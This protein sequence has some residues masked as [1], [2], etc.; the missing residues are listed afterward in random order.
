MMKTHAKLLFILL[1][2]QVCVC[3]AV[4]V[5][6]QGPAYRQYSDTGSLLVSKI[7]GTANGDV[8]TVFRTTTADSCA[9]IVQRSDSNG[10][11]RWTTRWP[12]LSVAEAAEAKNGDLLFSGSEWTATR[13]GGEARP[14]LLRTENDGSLLWRLDA[15]T[16]YP[17]PA[18][19]INRDQR[20]AETSTG[21][22]Y[23]HF[24]ESPGNTNDYFIYYV[25]AN[26]NTLWTRRLRYPSGFVFTDFISTFENN[27]LS[28]GT[29]PNGLAKGSFLIGIDSATN[30][31]FIRTITLPSSITIN[32]I[33]KDAVRR[34]YY[35]C[36]DY[37]DLATGVQAIVAKSGA[38]VASAISLQAVVAYP[39]LFKC[40]PAKRIYGLD[41]G[42]GVHCL[43]VSL[44]P[45]PLR[46]VTDGASLNAQ[47]PAWKF[48]ASL[49]VVW[50]KRYVMPL[51]AG[52]S[53]AFTSSPQLIFSHNRMMAAL[54]MDKPSASSVW[55][56][57]TDTAGV[58]A[59]NCVSTPEPFTSRNTSL[60]LNAVRANVVVPGV[61][62]NPSQTLV[63]QGYNVMARD[64]CIAPRK[65]KS[66]FR[67]AG[68]G[69]AICTGTAVSFLKHRLA[70]RKHGNGSF[71]RRP[72]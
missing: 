66:N 31:Q 60:P 10:V 25:N 6:A 23:Y 43:S 1:L 45:V 50:R 16:S 48:D 70:N 7:I 69:S 41:G 20:I 64:T 18:T 71:R 24:A 17:A 47:L 21:K 51:T 35:F 53:A 13:T 33:L 37:L 42:G 68:A 19:L 26:G 67:Y 49:K 38:D 27:T 11:V 57:S 22:I 14:F 55:L 2:I 59:G 62:M 72:I 30:L 61:L 56:L 9:S 36:G 46:T 28:C 32:Q 54:Q 12:N 44:S 63:Q 65:P 52:T 5:N 4:H 3:T 58:F 40:T 8:V 29:F 39:E 15:A 34:Q